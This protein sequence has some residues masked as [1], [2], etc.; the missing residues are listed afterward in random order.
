MPWV[1]PLERE[2]EGQKLMGRERSMKGARKRRERLKICNL[3][4]RSRI[5]SFLQEKGLIAEKVSI[6]P[7]HHLCNNELDLDIL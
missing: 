4:L 5:Y 1:P 7:A 2:T 3:C 6:N